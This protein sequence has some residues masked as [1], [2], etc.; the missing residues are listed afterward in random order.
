VAI[1]VAS[2]RIDFPEFGSVVIY[3]N[4]V[5]TYY[6]TLAGFLL[7]RTRFG[8]PVAAVS[9]PPSNM[10]DMATELFV[11][12]HIA[13]EKQAM[14]AARTGGTPG[15]TTGPVA[16]KSVGPV[17]ISY[18]PG[19]VVSEGAGFWNLTVYGMRFWKLV[20]MFGAGPIQ[21]GVGCAPLWNTGAWPGPLVWPGWQ[22]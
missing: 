3:P 1:T 14:D 15:V 13:I 8:C 17:S 22:G 18:S 10:Y 16:S 7:S 6:L 9:N 11:A 21:V 2:F 20:M 5:I 4:S 19:D 12:H